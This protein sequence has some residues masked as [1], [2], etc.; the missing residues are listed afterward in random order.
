[1]QSSKSEYYVL[2]ISNNN[3]DEKQFFIRV[4]K[5][6]VSRYKSFN[7]W[8]NTVDML[9]NGLEC[10]KSPVYEIELVTLKTLNSAVA[11]TVSD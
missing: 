6:K 3:M 4:F 5:S 2:L 10:F 8:A 9:H 1:M 7:M 11:L